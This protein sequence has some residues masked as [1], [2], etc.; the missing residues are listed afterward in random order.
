MKNFSPFLF[1]A[2]ILS[3]SIIWPAESSYLQTSHSIL[4]VQE[5]TDLSFFSHTIFQHSFKSA[6]PWVAG[7]II[8]S[9]KQSFFHPSLYIDLEGSLGSNGLIFH[10]TGIW[11]PFPDFGNQPAVGLRANVSSGF[12]TSKSFI[13]HS[14]IQLFTMKTFILNSRS[15]KSIIPFFA[16]LA[17]S[18]L[19]SFN[20]DWLVSGGFYMQYLTSRF[21]NSPPITGLEVQYSLDHFSILA[22]LV[23]PF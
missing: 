3:A 19:L 1:L 11:I 6:K 5:K 21:F 23:I 20:I 15:I 4:P 10:S 9:A 2:C 17:Q 16:P 8:A 14:Y 13:L 18:D 12:S 22:H 7:N